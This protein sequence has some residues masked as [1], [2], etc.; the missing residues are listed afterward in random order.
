MNDSVRKACDQLNCLSRSATKCT[1]MYAG[2]RQKALQQ[3]M[4]PIR[5]RMHVIAG[6]QTMSDD[7]GTHVAVPTSDD[8]PFHVRAAPEWS[9]RHRRDASW[10]QSRPCARSRIA[11]NFIIS[12]PASI[13]LAKKL[14]WFLK[15]LLFCRIVHG[16]TGCARPNQREIL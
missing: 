12:S 6:L 15:Q 7:N 14:E 3:P 8:G 1:Y 9:F 13:A 11:R 5:C 16:P 2:F 10:N 4:I